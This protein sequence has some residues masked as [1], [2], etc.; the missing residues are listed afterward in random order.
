MYI[1]DNISFKYFWIEKCF[2]ENWHTYLMFN[3]IL[4]QNRAIYKI[5]WKKIWY[6]QTDNR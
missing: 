5:M 3:N 4:P 2:R 1:Y 6:S